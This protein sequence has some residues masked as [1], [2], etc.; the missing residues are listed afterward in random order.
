[1]CQPRGDLDLAQES[2]LHDRGGQLGVQ[3]LDRDLAAVLEVLGEI[4]GRHAAASDLAI[5]PV[6]V[7][8]RPC[9]R[10]GVGRHG[11]GEFRSDGP[12]GARRSSLMS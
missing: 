3:H 7:G 9:Q 5:D 1:M 10:L 6:P 12:R 2:L 8:Q 11:P 4:D